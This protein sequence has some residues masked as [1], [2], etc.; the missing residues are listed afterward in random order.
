MVTLIRE[1]LIGSRLDPKNIG[2]VC[3][4]SGIGSDPV[5]GRLVHNV[6]ISVGTQ[7]FLHTVCVAPIKDNCLFGLDFMIATRSVLDLSRNTLTVVDDV[8]PIRVNKHPGLQASNVSIVRRTVIQSVGFVPAKLDSQI[9]GSYIVSGASNK[10]ALV[11][12][13][14][15]NGVS[16][17]LKVVNYS[18]SYV[19]FKK[20]KSIGHAVC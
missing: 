4:L 8:M 14:F 1:G 18:D 13:V 11:S 17:I 3:V 7:T 16:V 6:P 12:K 9:D 20:G 15:G 19:T 10:K 2:P 5:H